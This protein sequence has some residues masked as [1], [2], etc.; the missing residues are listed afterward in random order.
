MNI[1]LPFSKW[2][3][4]LLPPPPVSLRFLCW[5][6]WLSVLL[7][8]FACF[9]CLSNLSVYFPLVLSTSSAKMYT[10]LHSTSILI[11]ICSLERPTQKKKPR[12]EKKEKVRPPENR[13][14]QWECWPDRQ[15]FYGLLVFS[16][17]KALP[18]LSEWP[19]L[20]YIIYAHVAN[21]TLC[22]G[23]CV[24]PVHTFRVLLKGW[25]IRSV[26]KLTYNL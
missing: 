14:S 2:L 4:S 9:F 24:P 12:K 20:A 23:P 19:L 11:Q 6:K 13:H 26:L 7:V 5:L 10:L 22:F 18:S 16:L 1:P 15:T 3:T 21:A 17:S 8:L 25:K